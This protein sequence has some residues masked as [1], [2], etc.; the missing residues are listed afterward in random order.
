[1]NLN[2]CKT[3]VLLQYNLSVLAIASIGIVPD[4]IF[5][6]SYFIFF[7]LFGFYC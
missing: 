6:L 4:F 1:M 7:L 3:S 5:M 2:F